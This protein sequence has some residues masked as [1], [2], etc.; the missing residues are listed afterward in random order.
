MQSMQDIIQQC[1]ERREK[2]MQQRETIVSPTL[3]GEYPYH[4]IVY[5]GRRCPLLL[6]DLEQADISFMPIGQAPKFDR[7]PAYRGG[8]R[9]LRRQSTLNWE[10][11]RWFS[12][13][14]IQVYTGTPSARD[15]ANWHDIE[16]TY[17]AIRDA[18]D[19]V[20]ACLEALVNAVMNPL[21]TLLKGGGLR[22]SCRVPDYLHPHT[23]DARQY[24]HKHLPDIDH[25]DRDIYVEIIGDKGY[26]RWDARYE[27]LTGSLLNPPI[28]SK[29][30]L[31]AFLDVLRELL[32]EPAPVSE[33][34]TTNEALVDTQDFDDFDVIESLETEQ[35]VHE[36]ILAVRRGE[37]SP[38][39]IKRP[40]PLLGKVERA[41][42]KDERNLSEVEARILGII[43][44][45]IS[46]ERKREIEAT[47]L[48]TAPIWVN[49]NTTH[50]A[51]DT[52]R[53]YERQGVSV[54]RWKPRNHRWEQVKWIPIAERIQNPFARGNVCEDAERCDA[55]EQKGGD[56]NKS[57]CPSCP[58]YD[59][60]Q[61]RG[62]LSQLETLKQKQVIV[63]HI[64][65]LFLDRRYAAFV[66]ALIVPDRACI[67]DDSES[68]L[69]KL[70]SEH[71]LSTEILENWLINW[72]R[73][74]L[75]QFAKTVLNAIRITDSQHGDIAKRI[76][77]VVQ[78]L[79]GLEDSIIQQMCQVNSTDKEGSRITIDTDSAIDGSTSEN[80]EKFPSV[81]RDP[82]WTLWHQLKTFFAYY[83]R[84]IDAPM[85][86]SDRILRFWLPP[87]IHQEIQH[88]VF[89]SPAF[90]EECFKEV[91]PKEAV[92][93]KRVESPE[94]PLSG[95]KSFQLRSAPHISHAIANYEVNWDVFSL[96]KIANRFFT[97]IYQEIK[98]HPDLNH[99]VIS[100]TSAKIMLKNVFNNVISYHDLIKDTSA[101]PEDLR[102]IFGV[103][104]TYYNRIEGLRSTFKAADVF[105]VV[106]APYWSPKFMWEQAKVLFGNQ[107]KP[108]NYNLTM[109]P[110][111]FEDKRIQDLYEQNAIGA[112]T[113]IVR[114]F[115]FNEASGKT[116]VLNAALRIPSIT[117]APETELF[118]W[119]DFELAGGLDKLS[120]TIRIREAHQVEH[121]N[122]DASWSR[123][124]VEYLLGVSKSQANRIL[125]RL[126]GSKLQRTPFHVQI[127]ELL[128]DGQKTTPEILE[129]I[130]G[131]PGSIKN[132]LTRLIETGEI[133]R[134]RRGVYALA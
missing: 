89:I 28:I 45:P 1:H 62:Y 46:T 114:I 66:D 73:A 106:G 107:E 54:G 70:F 98:R 49:A 21:L 58:V 48:D 39:G 112:L 38:I 113:Q 56:P 127:F 8:T 111:Q 61:A 87:R 80:I 77:T 91:F 33:L 6:H 101:H 92:S 55:L 133:V 23:T 116:L 34:D 72:S 40:R 109:N 16:F 30:V 26:T 110:Y 78:A 36:S 124:R 134:V 15:G 47:F 3:H 60:C 102:S 90:S 25:R 88:L 104:H 52:E 5:C 129:A 99:V 67:I 18:P 126:R 65:N 32:H 17:R 122:M 79:E 35:C 20:V 96:S 13:W 71:H 22:F 118:D 12:S 128:S 68:Q 50:N 97:G 119:E 95:N 108:L 64:P 24:V 7:G 105:W 43:T 83:T 86:V 130:D 69:T 132:E 51:E 76:R 9:L 63:S 93:V 131:N 115:G 59:A 100:S 37:L 53:Y 10:P 81:Y 11:R 117:D 57:I 82:E 2:D 74:A 41:P 27:I 103:D 4:Y 125:M 123:E 94:T 31:F 84:D 42:V 75:G 120:E 19:A 121:Q 44:G 14:G 29:D 85:F